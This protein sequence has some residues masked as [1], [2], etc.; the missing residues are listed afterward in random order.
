MQYFGVFR[1]EIMTSTEFIELQDSILRLSGKELAELLKCDPG[2]VSR[3]RKS[4]R[5]IP[6]YIAQQMTMLVAEHL[7]TLKFPMSLD[8][9]F[10]LSRI[11]VADGISVEALMIRMI[12][13]EVA[14]S[15]PKVTPFPTEETDPLPSS[16]VAEDQ[17]D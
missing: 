14:R 5:P 9:L 7:K 16:R 4:E 12:R 17:P 15:S 11:A 2:S 3:W 6:S 10:A 8:D 1:W 13:S